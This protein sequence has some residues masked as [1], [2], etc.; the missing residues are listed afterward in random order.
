MSNLYQIMR[1]LKSDKSQTS[2][3]GDTDQSPDKSS[4][5]VTPTIR[6]GRK[7]EAEDVLIEASV[8][9]IPPEDDYV[10]DEALEA[11]IPPPSH[12]HHH[13][14]HNHEEVAH[15]VE[16]NGGKLSSFLSRNV[17]TLSRD[18]LVQGDSGSVVSELTYDHALRPLSHQQVL[19][20]LASRRIQEEVASCESGD[21][22]RTRGNT[23]AVSEETSY[24]NSFQMNEDVLPPLH[25]RA[26]DTDDASLSG[27][28]QPLVTPSP[29]ASLQN[30]QQFANGQGNSWRASAFGTDSTEESLQYSEQDSTVNH[31]VLSTDDQSNSLF[32]VSTHGYSVKSRSFRQSRVETVVE[33]VTQHEDSD[34]VDIE[35]EAM[36]AHRAT[37]NRFLP[38][39]PSR[40][41]DSV[42]F[43]EKDVVDY[44][45]RGAAYLSSTTGSYVSTSYVSTTTT[46]YSA[47]P[48][49][50]S[51]STTGVTTSAD[52]SVDDDSD[53]TTRASNFAGDDSV[54]L[55]SFGG[56]YT[57]SVTEKSETCAVPTTTAQLDEQHYTPSSETTV[58]EF[59]GNTSLPALSPY[60]DEDMSVSQGSTLLVDLDTL[61][62]SEVS[63]PTGADKGNQDIYADASLQQT[64]A[65]DRSEDSN[66]VLLSSADAE[67]VE[68]RA[69]GED[70]SI[71]VDST[72]LAVPTLADNLVGSTL[73]KNEIGSNMVSTK[74]ESSSQDAA[75]IALAPHSPAKTAKAE[76]QDS[77]QDVKKPNQLPVARQEE[78][79]PKPL[80]DHGLGPESSA[81]DLEQPNTENPYPGP[82]AISPSSHP[83]NMTAATRQE[84]WRPKPLI[85]HVSLES[86]TTDL[87]RPTPYLE[88]QKD[89]KR[90]SRC[91]NWK[92]TLICIGIVVV[93]GILAV[94]A[95]VIPLVVIHSRS[96]HRKLRGVSHALAVKT[97]PLASMIGV[98]PPLQAA[99]AAHQ[100]GQTRYA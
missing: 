87:E 22:P 81:T 54:D 53:A 29:H 12:H 75:P 8:E 86:S 16:N 90:T 42:D 77:K 32:S 92:W 7:K 40:N 94:P 88:S 70:T 76:D 64:S 55:V 56:L 13:H 93:L 20:S 99:L 98:T 74:E 51:R 23:T 30:I 89:E 14:H 31:E 4:S 34:E 97:T 17:G 35:A 47:Q 62:K 50:K 96:S 57:Q 28:H 11:D 80:M 69:S 49:V 83:S 19:T 33:E 9:D 27:L 48:S 41:D 73:D 82:A 71:L 100:R 66:K 61:P 78:W 21:T 18:I 52:I 85:D 72:N 59:E 5:D 68:T 65:F 84:E 24:D 10:E 25:E 3:V 44:S 39:L 43:S 95:V 1:H 67:Q 6:H 37:R 46:D 58:T 45:D 36:V 26:H 38:S 2:S 15:R 60:T 91:S 79:R 63:F